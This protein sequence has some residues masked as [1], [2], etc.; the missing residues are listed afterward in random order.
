M[1]TNLRGELTVPH[2]NR[3]KDLELFETVARILHLSSGEEMDR[4][5]DIFFPSLL[6]AAAKVCY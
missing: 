6:C 5:E 2:E 3:I 1:M 4:M